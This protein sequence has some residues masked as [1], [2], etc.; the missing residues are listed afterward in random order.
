MYTIIPR[1]LG[2]QLE[3]QSTSLGRGNNLGSN[4]LTSASQFFYL[5]NDNYFGPI[6]ASCTEITCVQIFFPL[7]LKVEIC[8]IYLW[9]SQAIHNV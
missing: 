8:F 4:P 2:Q 5:P 7:P 9:V 3:K 1:G 6:T